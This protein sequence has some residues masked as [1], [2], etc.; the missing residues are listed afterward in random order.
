[1]KIEAL[2]PIHSNG[3]LIAAITSL[4][5][6]GAH[7]RTWTSADGTKTFEGE[8]KSYDPSIALVTVALANG[9]SM[10]FEQDKLSAADI[11][12]LKAYFK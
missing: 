11:A 1:M 2:K 6:S 8:I 4:L 5:I 9:T 10:H 12:Y 3:L 7:A